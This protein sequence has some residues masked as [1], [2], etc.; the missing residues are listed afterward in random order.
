MKKITMPLM[1]AA[2]LFIVSCSGPSA[3]QANVTDAQ[4]VTENGGAEAHVDTHTSIIEWI[5][6]KKSGTQH[7]GTIQVK[8]GTLNFDQN[9]LVGGHFIIDMN[10]IHPVDQDEEN[11][12]KLLAHLNSDDFFGVDVHPEAHFNITAVSPVTD[13]GSLDMKDATHM[14]SGNLNLKG[15]EKNIT[16]P[17]K[18]N[19]T[20]SEFTAKS[21]F[22]LIRTDFNVM[23]GNENDP[24]FKDDFINKEI[25]LT[26]LLHGTR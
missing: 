22:N 26:I 9:E 14:I 16:I 23:F 21:V 4:E 1:L 18:V 10:T 2:T 12:N 19:I 13:A 11:N 17:A 5:G 25:H 15:I 20:D 8:S 24:S 3:D 7:N 6:S